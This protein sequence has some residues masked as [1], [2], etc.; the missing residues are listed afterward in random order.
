MMMTQPSLP[1]AEPVHAPA[2]IDSVSARQRAD[3][4]TVRTREDVTLAAWKT[5]LVES[6]FQ[7]AFT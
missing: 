7:P 5:L 3:A 2:K 1:A 6:V 4:R